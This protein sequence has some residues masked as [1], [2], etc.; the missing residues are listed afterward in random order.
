MFCLVKHILMC[1]KMSTKLGNN[2][3]LELNITELS[4]GAL[5]FLYKC[6]PQW[7]RARNWLLLSDV[8]RQLD[9]SRME[10]LACNRTLRRATM[11]RHDFI[12]ATE[13]SQLNC[14]PSSLMT[15]TS[16]N[17]TVELLEL[18]SD[19]RNI[20]HIEEDYIWV[21]NQ[22]LKMWNFLPTTSWLE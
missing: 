9:T 21:W 2:C 20:L 8:T 22:T 1:L 13:H 5:H 3:D 11:T 15:Q 12:M 10:F 6:F 4:I 19:L 7:H 16:R 18:T 17:S 14:A